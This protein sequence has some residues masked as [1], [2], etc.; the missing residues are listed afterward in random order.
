MNLET[1]LPSSMCPSYP[2]NVWNKIKEYD[3]E[4][5]LRWNMRRCRWELWRQG[6]NQYCMVLRVE[7]PNGS[8]R[9]V[10]ERLLW[11]LVNNDGWRYKNSR[12]IE[13]E[14]RDDE[15]QATRKK[16]ALIEDH[17]RQFFKEHRRFISRDLD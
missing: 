1:V 14:M 8:Y 15:E 7:N 12:E 11:Y 17:T 13:R 6:R 5:E 10:D 9:P 4:L 16:D 3:R 2:R